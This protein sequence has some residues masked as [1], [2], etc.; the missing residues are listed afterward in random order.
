MAN[1]RPRAD[2]LDMYRQTSNSIAP[3]HGRRS[4]IQNIQTPEPNV[5]NE[6][7]IQLCTFMPFSKHLHDCTVQQ[8]VEANVSLNFRFQELRFLCPSGSTVVWPINRLTAREQSVL[9]L[10]DLPYCKLVGLMHHVYSNTGSMTLEPIGLR[11]LLQKERI[12]DS[13][14]NHKLCD[15]NFIMFES[16]LTQAFMFCP[17][18]IENDVETNMSKKRKSNWDLSV[19]H[20]EVPKTKLVCE[21]IYFNYFTMTFCVGAKEPWKCKM[22]PTVLVPSLSSIWQE[23]VLHQALSLM[24]IVSSKR[25]PRQMEAQNSISDGLYPAHGTTLIITND[26]S[27]WASAC[28][29]LDIPVQEVN[30]RGVQVSDL[31]VP[32]VLLVSPNNLLQNFLQGD[33]I[34][35]D[36]FECFQVIQQG[37]SGVAMSQMVRYLVHSFAARYTNSVLPITYVQFGLLIYDDVE[38]LSDLTRTMLSDNNALRQ[39]QVFK[40]SKHTKPRCLT[41]EQCKIAL[42]KDEDSDLPSWVGPHLEALLEQ[43]TY[44]VPVHKSVLKRFKIFGHAI[45][46][47]QVEDRISKTFM[48]KFC[49]VAYEDALQRFSNS[50]M[51]VSVA[52]EL[53]KNHFQRLQMSFGQFL[54]P[55]SR[56]EDEE[57]IPIRAEFVTNALQKG[58]KSCSICFDEPEKAYVMTI[59]GHTLCEECT[60]IQFATEWAA[61]KAKDCPVCRTALTQGDVFYIQNNAGTSGT[62]SP[63]L[64]AKHAAVSNFLSSLRSMSQV[65]MW[66][67]NLLHEDDTKSFMKELEA[68]VKH[69]VITDI[70]NVSAIDILKGLQAQTGSINIHIFYNSFEVPWYYNFVSKF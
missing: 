54:K 21:P 38:G 50:V 44:V 58:T 30:H 69:I 47:G 51:P 6:Q 1:L 7:M 8:V 57:A 28:K 2:S 35:D 46:S 67:T 11:V 43:H 37:S 59:C 23:H 32:S 64:S 9:Q 41:E 19:R 5:M 33:S 29:G 45:K 68:P 4:L 25:A 13:F 62:Y 24:G 3:V 42:L 53:V 34:I 22:R 65:V 40:D 18:T 27:Q 56:N 36:F 61:F 60:T 16:N 14:L 55:Y 10:F 39:I 20:F 70:P 12:R 26:I 52:N 17:F 66:K 49:P 15:T 48:S 63:I 31:L